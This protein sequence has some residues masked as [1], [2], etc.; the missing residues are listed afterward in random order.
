MK[1]TVYNVIVDRD[2]MTKASRQCWPWEFPVLESKFPDGLVR[3]TGV[4]FCERDGLPDAG[5]EFSRLSNQ[6][7]VHEDTKIPHV[8][9]AYDRGDKGVKMMAKVIKD[10]VYDAKKEAAKLVKAAKEAAKVA[11]D[12]AKAAE[13]EA[14]KIDAAEAKEKADAAAEAADDPLS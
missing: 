9:L 6:Y 7:K 13:A 11:K 12:A 14:A 2:P 1:I 3:V 10:S 4:E 8:D 5:A